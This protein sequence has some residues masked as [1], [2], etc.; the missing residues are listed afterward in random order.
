MPEA[1]RLSAQFPLAVH[2]ARARTGFTL[3]ELLVVIAI[4]G[5][6]AALLLPALGRAKER[7]REIKCL[8]NARQLAIAVALYTEEHD[9]ELP[10]STD[11]TAPTSLPERIW[12]VRIQPYVSSEEILNCPSAPR[13]AFA[14]NWAARGWVSI[15]YTTATAY[16]PSLAE[17]FASATKQAVMEDPS[18]TPLFGDTASGPTEEKYRG[19]VFDPYNGQA[20]PND[21]RLGTPLLADRDLVKELS[22][23][24][25]A[26]LKPLHARHSARG[27]DS[28]RA[29]VLFGDGHAGVYTATAIL[30][31]DRG[32]ALHWR[33]RPAPTAGS[34]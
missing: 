16:D 18:L 1:F 30:A 6:L 5:I 15:G 33:F 19:Y 10:P 4:I 27:D 28:G 17:G 3:I 32:A 34:P 11:Y 8:S 7:S 24:P 23:L 31:Q 13:S 2:P 14:S 12:P 9:G 29:I 21:A 25:P 26:A 22:S 20:N